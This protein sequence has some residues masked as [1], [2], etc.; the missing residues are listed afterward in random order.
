MV[1]Q[2]S[3]IKRIDDLLGE[4]DNMR[5]KSK[6]DD[7]SDLKG[8]GDISK[9]ETRALATIESISAP[10][11]A[12][13]KQASYK[14]ANSGYLQVAS[15]PNLVGILQALKA[16]ITDG[17]LW[18]MNE[19]IHADI[20]ADFIEMARYL[21]EEKYKDAAAVL[22]GG[23]LEEHLR[24]LCVKNSIPIHIVKNDKNVYKKAGQMK[25]KLGGGFVDEDGDGICDR[26]QDADGDGVP[27][28]QDADWV[29]PQDGSGNK[30]GQRAGNGKGFAGR[31][32][33]G[34]NSGN[35][36]GTGDCDGTGPRGSQNKGNGSGK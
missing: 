28:G 23:T 13:A 35:A 30:F 34:G 18:K 9:F 16:D 33:R 26:F 20:F 1:E 7:L 27:N 17:Y 21:L 32:F 36:A 25:G 24:K 29:K 19:L 6:Y 8:D 11:S 3:L 31:G 5:S 10:N 15:I 2:E 12:Y 14:D 22:V 4:Y